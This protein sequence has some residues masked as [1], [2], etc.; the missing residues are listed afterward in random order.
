MLS[1]VHAQAK[2]KH[3]EV[4]Y[5]AMNHGYPT[6]HTLSPAPY[7]EV[8]SSVLERH[9]PSNTFCKGVTPTAGP[10]NELY[11]EPR[12]SM[13]PSYSGSPQAVTRISPHVQPTQVPQNSFESTVPGNFPAPATTQEHMRFVNFGQEPE[14]SA[15]AR[16]I[17]HTQPQRHQLQ[18]GS[19]MFF[20]TPPM[21]TNSLPDSCPSLPPLAQRKRAP[22]RE[23]QR[24]GLARLNIPAAPSRGAAQQPVSHPYSRP[25]NVRQ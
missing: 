5:T 19:A 11:A 10:Y 18:S 16:H 3:R 9:A 17:W 25:V 22:L 23:D 21:E 4:P 20:P 8:R 24:R 7:L 13:G 2:G 6:P 1:P 14:G 12:S 15:S